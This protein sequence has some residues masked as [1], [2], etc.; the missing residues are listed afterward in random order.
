[1]RYHY[2]SI[3]ICQLILVDF[4]CGQADL[5]KTYPENQAFKV[6]LIYATFAP[7]FHEVQCCKFGAVVLYSN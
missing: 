7:F 5:K 3:A 4:M 1:M 6:A 2:Q